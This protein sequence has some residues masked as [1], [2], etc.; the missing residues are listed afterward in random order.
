MESDFGF[1]EVSSNLRRGTIHS[2]PD[3][4][5]DRLSRIQTQW[6]L[7]ARA[8]HGDSGPAQAARH[9]L[10]ERYLRGVFRYVLAI[11][12]DP[13]A[14]EELTQEFSVRFLRG[15]FEGADADRGRFRDYLKRALV[16]LVRSE[17]RRLARWPG[18]LPEGLAEP[19]PPDDAEFASAWRDELLDQTWQALEHENPGYAAALQC[20][21]AH[22]NLTSAELAVELSRETGRDLN[23]AA[24]R[25][26]LQRAHQKF[27][28]LL[29]EEVR[30]S[31]GAGSPQALHEELQALNLLQFCRSVVE[32]ASGA[33]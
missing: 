13:H 22:P 21:I 16:N 5:F 3:T 9:A 8:H 30:Q 10:L 15:D 31:L 1:D 23:A 18:E 6:T 4:T 2:M 28:E 14:A 19:S 26:T 12:K 17:W 33:V 20:R 29:V 24:I 7:L 32:Q 25:K 11:T 27:A